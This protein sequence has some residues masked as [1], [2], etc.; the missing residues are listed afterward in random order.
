MGLCGGCANLWAP[1]PWTEHYDPRYPDHRRTW[2]LCEAA[3]R[4]PT[5]FTRCMQESLVIYPDLPPTLA[6]PLHL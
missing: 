5:D 3:S 4:A 6:R 2:E 1:L